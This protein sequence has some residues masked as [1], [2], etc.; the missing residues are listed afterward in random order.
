MPSTSTADATTRVRRF[1]FRS[2]GSPEPTPRHQVRRALQ[3]PGQTPSRLG[4]LPE[5]SA[6]PRRF[7]QS[8]RSRHLHLAP[9]AGRGR[10]SGAREGE[11]GGGGR[12]GGGGGGDSP[13]VR[14]RG[15]SPSPRPSPRKGGAREK[16]RRSCMN[17]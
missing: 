7:G 10:P 11:G 2:Y 14:T 17:W 12:G 9:L 3:T 16:R 13:R 6:D 8:H 5:P 4:S 1:M 15:K